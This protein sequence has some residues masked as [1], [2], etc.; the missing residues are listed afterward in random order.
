MLQYNKDNIP[1]QRV[2]FTFKNVRTVTD[3][4]NILHT[5]FFVVLLD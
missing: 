5:H 1:L 2:T 4:E 3:L